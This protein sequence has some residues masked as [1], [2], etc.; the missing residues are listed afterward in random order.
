MAILARDN[1]TQF[2]PAP[3]GL[4]QAVCV[5][6]VDRGMVKTQWGEKHQIQIRW[7]LECVNDET[8]KR[9][10][11]VATFTN[12]LNEKANLRKSL[13]AWMGRDFT[14]DE[15]DKGFDLERLIGANCQ[16]QIIHN[17][18]SNGKTYGNVQAI[19]RLGKGQAKMEAED[20]IRMQDRPQNG[21]GPQDQVGAEA[22]PDAD[23]PF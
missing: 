5:D 4:H 13:K 16:I 18:A 10:M 8:K 11:A 17:L 7:Q 22:D 2:T 3:E 21:S 23:I 15:L 19:V 9:H 6:V 12:S 14:P 1:Q 20:Y